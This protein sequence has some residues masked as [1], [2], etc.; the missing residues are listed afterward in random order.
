MRITRYENFAE[1][2]NIIRLI[3]A[4]PDNVQIINEL[5]N[6][7]PLL[8]ESFRQYMLRLSSP[9]SASLWIIM[10]LTLR[11]Y[12]EAAG[13]VISMIALRRLIKG[14]AKSGLPMRDL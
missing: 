10:E 6:N 4:N 7:P 8:D 14:R 2:G 11:L 13:N 3:Y 12:S 1:I 9:T 5:A